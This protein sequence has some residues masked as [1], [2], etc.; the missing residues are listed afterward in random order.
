MSLGPIISV[1]NRT[2]AP[3]TKGTLTD[4]TSGLTSPGKNSLDIRLE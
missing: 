1:K 4:Q 2:Q 3:F